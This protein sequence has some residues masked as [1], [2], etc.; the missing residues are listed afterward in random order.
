MCNC[1]PAL[2]RQPPRHVKLS[3]RELRHLH[4]LL[5][6]L[7]EVADGD[8]VQAAL[9]DDLLALLHVGADE[10]D[11][12]RLREANLL[13]GGHDAVGDDVAAHDAA[14]DVDEDRLDVRVALDDLEG[15]GDG[16]LVG[17]A[18]DVQEVGRGAAAER[19][20]VHGGHREAGAVDHASNAAGQLDVVQVEFLGLN[21][22]GILLQEVPLFVDGLL[23]EFRVVVEADLSVADDDPAVGEFREGVDLDH[24][25]VAFDEDLVEALDA[26]CRGG[27]LRPGET[28]F[29]GHVQGLRRADALHDVDGQLHDGARVLLGDVLDRGAAGLAADHDGAAAAAVHQDGE[30]LLG[31]DLK[32]LGEHDDI[33]RLA[34]STGLLGDE[35]LAEHLL[36]ELSGLVLVDDVHPALEVVLLE[37]AQAAS[38][39]QDL[40][41]DDD[42]VAGEALRDLGGLG[43]GLGNCDLR[44]CDAEVLEESERLVFVKAE[45]TA[46]P[47]GPGQRTAPRVRR[48]GTDEWHC[49]EHCGGDKGGGTAWNG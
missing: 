38:A 2:H 40:R 8:D 3:L 9:L 27:G 7:R 49:G 46:R 11:D 25:A 39:G 42:L 16:V 30:I 5:R 21:F 32:L 36:R 12:Q 1:A 45:V 28:H 4:G 6:G 20:E 17:G 34:R 35:G 23:P 14:E 10:P 29:L 41:L 47:Q 18:T 15:G 22:L 48:G 43:D 37:V 31:L 24:G 33:A 13:H 44:H 19:E 26:L